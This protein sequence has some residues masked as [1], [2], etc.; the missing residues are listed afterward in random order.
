MCCGTT[1]CIV[2]LRVYDVDWCRRLAIPCSRSLPAWFF[3]MH[4]LLIRLCFFCATIPGW[5]PAHSQNSLFEGPPVNYLKAPVRDAVSALAGQVQA[6]QSSLAY[7]AQYGYLLSVLEALD[8]SL[9]SQTLVFYKTSLQLNRISPARPRALY[10]NDDVYVGWCQRGDV[11]ELA[12]TDPEQ[13]AIF[14]TVPQTQMTAPEFIRDNGQCLSCHASART[15]NIPGYL[16]RSVYPDRQGQPLLRRG[17]FTIDHTSPLEQRWGGWYVTGQHGTMRHLGNLLVDS[18]EAD[19]DLEQGANRQSLQGLVSTAAYPT[20]HSDIVALMVLEHQTQTHNALAA[21]NFETRHATYQSYAMNELLD[22]PADQ[23][24]ESAQRR[25]DKSVERLVRY[26]FFSD[27]LPL[28]SPIVGTSGYSEYFASLGPEDSRGR[29]LRQFDLT[30]RIFRYPCSYLV[31]SEAFLNLPPE[32]KH[33]TLQSMTEILQ[34]ERKG[35][36]FKHLTPTLRQEILE[37]LVATHPDFSN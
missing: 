30:S 6:G 2:Y 36:E 5:S 15:Q 19:L 25:I 27:E 8:I 21:A 22:R 23:L 34:G 10:F 4:R 32:A 12:V 1:A 37:I 13:G 24:S 26:I 3:P 17:T 18:D 35:T 16:I 29:S 28:G 14:Y 9:T 7:D 20:Q 33:R 11:L 31:Y